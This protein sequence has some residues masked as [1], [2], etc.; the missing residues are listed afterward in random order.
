[1]PAADVPAVPRL[2]VIPGGAS[3]DFEPGAMPPVSV[4][5]PGTAPADSGR[6]LTWQEARALAL[7]GARKAQEELRREA[8]SQARFD[9]WLLEETGEP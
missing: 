1:M 5:V 4:R 6:P 8:E 9:A 3:A 2:T 7:G